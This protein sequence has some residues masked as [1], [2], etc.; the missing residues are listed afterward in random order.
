MWAASE[1]EGT[2]KP[3]ANCKMHVTMQKR[4]SDGDVPCFLCRTLRRTQQSGARVLGT[5][6]RESQKS[7]PAFDLWVSPLGVDTQALQGETSSRFSP[8]NAANPGRFDT[9]G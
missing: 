6:C 1:S 3:C 7:E 2:P 8:R 5:W 9:E 4:I